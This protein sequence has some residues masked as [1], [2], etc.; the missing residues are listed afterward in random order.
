MS[1][2]VKLREK[3]A[4]E[5]SFN[6]WRGKIKEELGKTAFRF[7]PVISF[8]DGSR[9]INVH[10]DGSLTK[11]IGRVS[12]PI[13][14]LPEYALRAYVTLTHP[15]LYIRIIKSKKKKSKVASEVDKMAAAIVDN[16]RQELETRFA[17]YMKNAL[18]VARALPELPSGSRSLR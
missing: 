4:F 2:E 15:E 1:P 3:S 18:R 9:S 5:D 14:S 7:L 8:D 17:L 10:R 16:N 6:S 12:S 13:T 11:H